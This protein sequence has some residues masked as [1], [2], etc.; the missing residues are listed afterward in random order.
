MRVRLLIPLRHQYP[1]R[2]P[3]RMGGAVGLC[4]VGFGRIGMSW[5]G[6]LW[7]GVFVPR[8]LIMRRGAWVLGGV[9]IRAVLYD[10]KG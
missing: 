9:C 2:R 7:G 4:D 10:W 3:R 5:V 1:R 8:R 6:L